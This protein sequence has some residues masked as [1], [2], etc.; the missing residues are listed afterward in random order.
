MAYKAEQQPRK[1][2][3]LEQL[4]SLWAGNFGALVPCSRASQNASTAPGTARVFPTLSNTYC[5]LIGR[6]RTHA[7]H[8][9]QTSTTALVSPLALSY[10][11][12]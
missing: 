8:L 4:P 1:P 3:S 6:L 9:E 10:E 2:F 12:P 7:K 5:I 11:Q